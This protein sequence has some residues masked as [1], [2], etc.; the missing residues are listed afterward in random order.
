MLRRGDEAERVAD[1]VRIVETA[2]QD[3][4]QRLVVAEY[5]GRLAGAVHLRLTTISP[6]NLD[7]TSVQRHAA[8]SVVSP[9][10]GSARRDGVGRGRGLM[11]DAAA[12]RSRDA[13]RFRRGSRSVRTPCAGR[14]PTPSASARRRR[15]ANAAAVVSCAPPLAALRPRVGSDWRWLGPGEAT[16]SRESLAEQR[17]GDA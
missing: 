4:D 3:P 5:D 1:L 6:L 17:A 12:S 2:G 8:A 14:R 15:P 10:F 16:D 13:N 9:E 7:P 11:R